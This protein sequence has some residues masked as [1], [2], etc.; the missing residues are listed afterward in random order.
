MRDLLMLSHEPV[1]QAPDLAETQM[2][3]ALAAAEDPAA[4]PVE[5]AEMLMEIARGLQLKPR[6]PRHLHDAIALC[7][8][9]LSLVPETD[10]LL[11]AR[12]RAREGSAHQALP[13][14]GVAALN[15]AMD[16]YERARPALE[17]LG[18]P[19]EC[20]EL[21]M[22][23]GLVTQSL[24]GIGRGLIKD[25]IA[26]YH[27]ALRVFNRT[28]HPR[29]FGILHN[30]LAIAYLSIPTVDEAGKLRE[31]L[32]VQ[33]FEQVLE[34]VTLVDHPSEY[35]MV[36]NNLGNA[37]QYAPSSHPVANLLRA[38]EAYDEALKVRNERDTPVEYAN[39]I[40]NKANALRN[41]PDDPER[42]ERGNAHQLAAARALYLRAREI[43]LRHDLTGNASA[44]ADAI[45]ELD[46]DAFRPF[47]E[48]IFPA[49]K[50]IQ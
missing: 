21:D 7:V 15:A 13:E 30:N 12:I 23:L 45:D 3:S 43:F 25:A 28:R 47:G 5:R 41:L 39:T 29:E 38:V 9:A 35:A 26:H 22:N 48:P 49:A 31:A 24:A 33:S 36:Q 16:C 14:G 11:A 10:R 8:R 4:T 6:S 40:A 50:E 44:I 46:V 1:D 20:A 27:R 32:A 17:A 2:R 42:P 18:L 37:L 34:V 19:E